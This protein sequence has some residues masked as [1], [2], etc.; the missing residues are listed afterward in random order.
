[1][2]NLRKRTTDK[3]NNIDSYILL[4]LSFTTTVQI[5]ELTKRT[6]RHFWNIASRIFLHHHD[7]FW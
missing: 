1:M 2:K 6:I 5:E 4:V 3:P 7:H